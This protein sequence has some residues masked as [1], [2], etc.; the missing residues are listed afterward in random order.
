MSLSGLPEQDVAMPGVVRAIAAGRRTRPVWI[1]ELGG[2]TFEIDPEGYDRSFVKFAPAG[3]GLPLAGEASRLRWARPFTPVPEVLDTG[4]DESGTWLWTGALPGRNAIEPRWKADPRPAV[5]AIG[6]GL[7][8]LHDRL[9]VD[10]CPF[11]W[12]AAERLA[13]ARADVAAGLI[14]PDRTGFP[15]LP[16][17]EA[18]A[19]LADVPDVDRLV[20]CHGD[21]CAPNTLLTDGGAWTGHVDMARLGVADRWADLA[22]GSWSLSWNYGDGWEPVFYDAYQIE[23]DPERVAYYRLLWD[24]TI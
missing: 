6:H 2:T 8:R 11:T 19:R 12:S 7:R 15:D 22:I 18:L 23:P 13:R 3:S 5:T 21:S 10:G 4:S 1:N 20:V 9:P 14:T 17:A 16:V 24:Y